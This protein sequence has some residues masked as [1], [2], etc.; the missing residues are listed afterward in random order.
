[1]PPSIN[2]REFVT[3]SLATGFALAVMPDAAAEVISTSSEG[4]VAG[5]VKIPAQGGD[6]PAYRAMPQG[7]GP[8]PM[9]LVVQEI[10]GVHEYI[11]DVCRRLAQAGYFAV[12]PELYARQGDVSKI[13]NI[14]DIVQKVVS[15]VP[16]AQVMG[17]LD[18]TVA[19]AKGTGKT[20]TARLGITGFCW[21]GRITWLYA[22]HN[23]T[24]KAGVAWYGRL[25]GDSTTLTPKHPL[26][27]A[28]A[29]NAP[30]LGLYG[31][32]DTGIPVASIEQMRAALKNANKTAEIV[33]YP[34]TPH[35]FHADYRPSYNAEAATD[36]WKRLL[37]WFKQNGV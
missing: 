1:M 5:E 36:G 11:R 9:I 35:G 24:L 27:V 21:G 37:A 3:V 32:A 18:K 16:D 20:D 28:D 17:D 4:L 7:K 29:L 34:D 14:P 26:D 2:R 8:F 33:V 13:A 30:I 22:A 23:P 6:M 31:G 25:V 15:K 19:W 12:A 10:F